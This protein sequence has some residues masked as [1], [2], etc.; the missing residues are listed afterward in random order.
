MPT[1]NFNQFAGY[2]NRK[3]IRLRGYDYSQ[4]GYYFITICVHD[5]T[6]RLFGNIVNGKM[7]LNELGTI[8]YNQFECLPERFP[9]IKLD[10]F[11]IM[12]NHIHT[13]IIVCE[14]PVGATLA[15][16]RDFT[17]VARDFN[18]VS[19]I[20]GTAV[21]RKNATE[22]NIVNA[23]R[24]GASPAPTGNVE[25]PTENTGTMEKNRN[26]I[27]ISIGGIIGAYKSLVSHECLRIYNPKNECMGKLWQRNYYDH[28]IRD[29]KTLFFIRKYIA[30]NPMKWDSDS[31]NHIDR[32]I[33]EFGMTEK[34]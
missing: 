18:T 2:H 15:V 6:Q 16:A 10:A 27:N 24:A 5:R 12:P 17:A 14:F 29:E 3:S 32:E 33:R 23:K 8:A 19:P 30:D 20:S 13:V 7:V 1:S 28:I 31:E 22:K 26:T 21:A 25:Q 9:K 4:S 34:M 11:Q